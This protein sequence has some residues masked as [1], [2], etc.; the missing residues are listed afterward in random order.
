[1]TPTMLFQAAMVT[2]RQVAQVFVIAG[3]SRACISTATVA[4][5][6]IHRNESKNRY[7]TLGLFLNIEFGFHFFELLNPGEVFIFV[8]HLIEISVVRSSI[9]K[10]R[11]EKWKFLETVSVYLL[12]LLCATRLLCFLFP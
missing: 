6:S 1:M 9:W 4:S 2:F 7:N 8:G 11:I 10:G 5:L 3:A 12:P